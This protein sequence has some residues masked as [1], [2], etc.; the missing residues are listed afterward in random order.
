[1]GSETTSCLQPNVAQR[2]L[3]SLPRVRQHAARRPEEEEPL[4]QQDA[5]D[6]SPCKKQDQL[7]GVL[8]A[9]QERFSKEGAS[10][11]TATVHEAL[12]KSQLDNKA[13]FRLYEHSIGFFLRH[14][15]VMKAS[16]LYARMTREGFIPTVSL[17]AQ[18]RI[19]TVAEQAAPDEVVLDAIRQAIANNSFN[20][21]TLLALLR[22][23]GD[24][25]RASP[26]FLENIV[27]EFLK[28]QPHDYEIYPRTRKYIVKAYLRVGDREGASRWSSG[29]FVPPPP[30]RSDL[31]SPYIT[32]LQDLA[33]SDPQFA[34]YETALVGMQAEMPSLIPNLPFFNALL[35]HEVH[36]RNFSAVFA[37]YQRMMALRSSTVMPDGGTFS[38]VFRAIARLSALSRKR[39]RLR[40]LRPPDSMPHP[41]AVYQDMLTCHAEQQTAPDPLVSPA[42]TL[43]AI[44]TALNAFMGGHDYPAAFNAIRAFRTYSSHIG[45]PVRI[46]YHVVVSGI[47]ERIK[48]ELPQVPL[49]A[50]QRRL[51]TFRFLGLDTLPRHRR[52]SIPFN[53]EML[54]RVLLMGTEPR[55]SLEFVDVPESDSHDEQAD[56]RAAQAQDDYAKHGIPTPLEF[57]G[58]EPVPEAK[59]FAIA[60]LERIL[61]RAILASIEDEVDPPYVRPVSAAIADAKAEMVPGG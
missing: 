57:V 1:M 51:W 45:E 12:S 3:S 10:A 29:R 38:A 9:L 27:H 34:G 44:H 5:H 13:R 23:L 53:L 19:I 40:E 48:A 56:P 18:M 41:R 6:P 47:L 2:H 36:R 46:T 22:I 52:A 60:P 42:L 11:A 43:P 50:D 39:R 58:A 31:P 14:G 35:S 21:G 25:M 7:A 24:G 32:L 49:E 28:I 59:A 33:A 54:Q 26:D 37:I 4:H 8:H 17:R 30:S 61:R 16:I 55:L 20:E 15:E